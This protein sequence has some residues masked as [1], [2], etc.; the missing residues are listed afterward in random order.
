MPN[1]KGFSVIGT[2]TNPVKNNVLELCEYLDKKATVN[3]NFVF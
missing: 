3:L 1:K 2:E